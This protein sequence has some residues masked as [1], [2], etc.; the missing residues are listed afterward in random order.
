MHGGGFYRSLKYR[1]APGTLPA[2]LHWFYWEAYTTWLSG[3]L[4]LCLLYLL[5]A[6][7][8]LVDPAVMP[9]SKSA[10]ILIALGTLVVTWLIYDAAVSLSARAPLARPGHNDRCA[11]RNPGLGAVPDVQRPRRLHDVW[12]GTGHDHGGECAVRDHS[13]AARTGARQAAG[14][15]GGSGTRAQGQAALAAQHL[16]YAAGAAGDDQQPLCDDLWGPQQ[17]AGADRPQFC[18]R[19][20]PRLVCGAPETGRA[21]A[22]RAACPS[23]WRRWRWAA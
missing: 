21:R 18:R 20:H 5:R 23:G 10:A 11:A 13:R 12:R 8:Y 19:L 7:A 1:I 17:L 16:F 9:L 4:L 6:E 15:G 2:T 3:F 14:A 22:T